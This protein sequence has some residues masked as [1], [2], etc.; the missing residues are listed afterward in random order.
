VHPNSLIIFFDLNEFS[1]KK[2]L[3]IFNNFSIV[4]QNITKPTLVVIKGFPR[5]N[6][7][8]ARD[9]MI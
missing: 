8:A 1:R 5:N 9:A 6:K 7:S 3:N 4:S 2:L